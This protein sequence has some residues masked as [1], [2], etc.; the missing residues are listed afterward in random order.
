MGPSRR[1][2]LKCRPPNYAFRHADDFGLL[3]M[4]F[5]TGRRELDEIDAFEK[6]RAVT[7]DT[8]FHRAM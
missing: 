4:D 6:E 3:Q 1:G 8:W 2:T 5:M 7:K